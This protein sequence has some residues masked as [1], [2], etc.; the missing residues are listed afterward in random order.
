MSNVRISELP[1]AT[2]PLTG[3]ELVPVVQ[4]GVTRQ[5]TAAAIGAGVVNV[6]AYGAAGDGVT[7]DT[8]A[9]QA[10]IVALRS[11]PADRI[12]TIGGNT[13]TMYRSGTL[14]FPL[15]VYR[16]TANTLQIVADMGLTFE[17]AG[18]RRF[19]NA[20]YGRTTLLITGTSSGYGIQ[21]YRNGARSAQFRDLDI[22]YESSSFTGH[23]IDCFDAPGLKF[24]N[25][26][27]GTYGI[28]GGTRQQTAASLLRLTYD[29]DVTLQ[30]CTLDG[31]VLGVFSDDTRTEL[32]NTFGGWGLCL[33]R[34]TFYDIT[35]AHIQHAGNRTRTTTTIKDCHF[36][37]INL[38]TARAVD[39]NNFDGLTMVGNIFSPSTTSYATTEWARLV[40]CTGTVTG[41]SFGSLS[42]SG[43]FN[44]QL[45]VSGNV[46]AGTD[47]VTLAGGVIT[48]R[49]NEFSTGTNGWTITPTQA[50]VFD[51]GP[52]LFKSGVTNS[53]RNAADSA[54]IAGNVRYDSSYDS[55]TG[56]FSISS[57][58][59]RIENVDRKQFS[60][61]T[62][63]YTLSV[64]DTGRTVRA[65]GGSAQTFTL[66]AP[67]PGCVLRVFK[68]S[69]VTLQIDGPAAASIYAGTGGLK[70]SISAAAG[71]VGGWVTFESW[72]AFN[73]II[74]SSFGTWTLA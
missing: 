58:R 56:K 29:E 68:A 62:T 9:I 33:D 57:G 20:I 63:P 55:S 31:A 23:L 8:A 18:S 24:F 5:T 4:A 25:C 12:D 30:D 72:D 47:G 69:N 19:T 3:T 74:T 21:F 32:G 17:G 38:S 52:D 45:E 71:D 27:L 49:A 44:G 13:I 34:V 35:T 64:L 36:N 2:L 14:S 16:L 10:A 53:I 59:I 26:Y 7:D 48:G 73:W 65:T 40:N 11:Y 43:T 60:V 41:N 22:C 42:K 37:P 50:L 1:A 28:T 67:Q 15:G 66:P 61:S 51:V 39:L 70:S 6:K 54:N 46:F